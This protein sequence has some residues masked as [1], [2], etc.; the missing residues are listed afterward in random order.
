VSPRPRWRYVQARLQ[1]RHGE[2]LSEADW[3][4]LEAAR[5]LDHFLERARG[6]PLRRFTERLNAGVTSHAIERLLRMSWRTYVAEVAGW[7]DRDWQP[8]VL[9]AAH[10]A[11]LPAINA[12]LRGE[13]PAWA[14]Q[15]SALAAFAEGN[16]L[17]RSAALENS[18]LAPLLPAPGRGTSLAHRWAAHWQ[19]LWP[20]SGRAETHGLH[21]LIAV[22]AAHAVQ[23]ALAAP[24]G[25]SPPHRLE[26]AKRLTRLFRQNG[27]S[28]AAVF[29]HLALAA[30]DLERLRGNLVRRRLFETTGVRE[31]A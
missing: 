28:P 11:D 25:T 9:W 17:Q 1:A 19:L 8:A 26:V 5:S 30:L 31:A 12:L 18:P 15:D 16:P 22:V 20:R 13:A 14:K 2:R 7:L 29:S 24:P 4:M 6:T 27:A 3:R 23:L 10:V 21:N